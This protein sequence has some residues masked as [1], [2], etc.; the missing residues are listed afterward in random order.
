M[1]QRQLYRRDALLDLRRMCLQARFLGAVPARQ[2]PRIL[3]DRPVSVAGDTVTLLS[4]DLRLR[5]SRGA[6]REAASTSS[7]RAESFTC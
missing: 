3:K 4:E 1:N 5:G 7:F 6:S 2:N